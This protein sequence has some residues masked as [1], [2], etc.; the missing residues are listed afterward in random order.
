[1]EAERR[2]V[3]WLSRA[4]SMIVGIWISDKLGRPRIEQWR[5]L[6][7]LKLLVHDGYPILGRSLCAP[8]N[9]FLPATRT[10]RILREDQ[11]FVEGGKSIDVA[12]TSCP[13]R[14]NH[15]LGLRRTAAGEAQRKFIG[16][17]YPSAVSRTPP[18]EISVTRRS[19]AVPSQRTIVTRYSTRWRGDRRLPRAQ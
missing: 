5:A 12:P 10:S 8:P 14:Q 19:R 16:D 9:A 4:Q 11:V 1:M 2:E 15:L 3:D 6:R 13:I 18:S 7:W 17:L